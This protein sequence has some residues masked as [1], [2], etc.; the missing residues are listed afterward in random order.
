MHYIPQRRHLLV[1]YTLKKSTQLTEDIFWNAVT[2]DTSLSLIY[3]SR[4]SDVRYTAD[5]VRGKRERERV[6]E[7]EG[8]NRS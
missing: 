2:Q 3:T 4:A 6:R 8:C 5:W 1:K 7:I